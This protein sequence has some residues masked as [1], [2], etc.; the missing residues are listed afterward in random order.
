MLVRYRSFTDAVADSSRH[1]RYGYFERIESAHPRSK[2]LLKI[3]TVVKDDKPW[4]LMVQVQCLIHNHEDLQHLVD[5]VIAAYDSTRGEHG[6][7][8]KTSPSELQLIRG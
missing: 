2:E 3:G 6:E 5:A 1:N 7:D 4:P 8:E